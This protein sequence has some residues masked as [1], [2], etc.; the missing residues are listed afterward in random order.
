MSV[1]ISS[2]RPYGLLTFE[3]LVDFVVSLKHQ[4]DLKYVLVKIH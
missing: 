3:G 2:Q 1:Y 4:R